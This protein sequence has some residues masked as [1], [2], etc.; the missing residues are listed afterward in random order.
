MQG[1]Y[2]VINN[3]PLQL[4]TRHENM[5]LV[6]VMPGPKEP[7]SYEY[8][9]MLQP[10]VEDLIALGKGTGLVVILDTILNSH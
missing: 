3:L 7:S 9:Q 6:M 4:R 5:I 1:V 8:N 2:I 10:L